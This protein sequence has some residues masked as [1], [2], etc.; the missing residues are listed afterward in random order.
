MLERD[1]GVTDQASL[2]ETVERLVTKGHNSEALDYLA[3]SGT[4]GMTREDLIT[5]METNGFDDE[6]Q[7]IMLAAFDA[8]NAYG[9]HAIAGWD[10]SRAMSLLGWG[11]LAGF[12]TYEE[13]MDK[14]LV[15]A[16]M[17]QQEFTSWDDFMNSYFYG[18]SYW[19]GNAPEDTDSQAYKRRRLFEE[20]KEED[21][22]P[23]SAD[24]NTSL[25]KVW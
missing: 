25:Q 17:I 1:W 10:L 15:T 8:K 16:Q 18:Y 9:D 23:F 12:Y 13:A 19:S 21:N 22:S 4:E 7:T 24:W 3:Q 5:A 20:I 11:Y 2:E 14:S 6:E